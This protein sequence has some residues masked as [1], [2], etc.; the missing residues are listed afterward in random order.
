MFFFSFIGLIKNPWNETESR[1]F[2]FRLK[3]R[4]GRE[5]RERDLVLPLITV[6][7]C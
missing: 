4:N 7:A 2:L 6:R 5:E 1:P 3:L